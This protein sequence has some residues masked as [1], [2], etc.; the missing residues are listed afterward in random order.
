L[1]CAFCSLLQVSYSSEMKIYVPMID[2]ICLLQEIGIRE[3]ILN[4]MELFMSAASFKYC[5]AYSYSDFSR[6]N[7]CIFAYNE[8]R[9]SCSPLYDL[10]E[11]NIIDN[12]SEQLYDLQFY[13]VSNCLPGRLQSLVLNSYLFYLNI[14]IK[15]FT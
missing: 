6:Y 8:K 15:T 11:E 9:R 1:F 7:Y 12:N 5:I 3:E 10:P 2:K 14:H 13:K 4:S